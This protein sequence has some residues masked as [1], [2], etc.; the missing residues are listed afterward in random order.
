MPDEAGVPSSGGVTVADVAYQQV[1]GQPMLARLYRPAR[2]VAALVEVHGGAWTSNDRLK[3]EPI[4]APLAADGTLVMSIDFRMPPQ[5]AYPASIADINLAVR[6]LKSRAA[7]FGIDA[8]KVGLLGTSSGGHQVLLA[9]VKPDD[10]RYGALP[11]PGGGAVDA[12]VAYAVACWPIADPLDRYRMA[13]REGKAN[14]VA[15]HDAYWGSEAAMQDGSP[16]RIV[17]SRSHA[18][19]PPIFIVHGTKDGNV[20]HTASERY[21]AT[22]REAG[23]SAEVKIYEGQPHAFIGENVG[24][25]DSM[26]AIARIAAFIRR[27]GR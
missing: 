27:H 19:L 9:A 20:R 25:P 22:Y 2:P 18:A 4:V 15:N 10:P 21:A 13:Q 14:L 6:W 17:E 8:A 16:Q 24:H 26:D 7:E 1:D 11:L 3:N 23:G 5:A 12:S